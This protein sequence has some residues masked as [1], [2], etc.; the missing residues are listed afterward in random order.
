M[1]QECMIAKYKGYLEDKEGVSIEDIGI[2]TLVII[3]LSNKEGS[4]N[5]YV[6]M[7]LK[8][9]FQIILENRSNLGFS[10]LLSEVYKVLFQLVN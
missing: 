2:N 10:D 6:M 9:N 5:K 4:L 1:V 7:H 8:R 3:S